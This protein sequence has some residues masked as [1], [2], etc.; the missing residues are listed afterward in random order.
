MASQEPLLARQ[1]DVDHAAHRS[2]ATGDEV[3]D[4]TSNLQLSIASASALVGR[5]DGVDLQRKAIEQSL[6]H[7]MSQ[8]RPLS[9]ALSLLHRTAKVYTLTERYLQVAALVDSLAAQIASKIAAIHSCAAD[10][11]HQVAEHIDCVFDKISKLQSVRQ[12]LQQSSS[13][14]NLASM[15]GAQTQ[16]A[17]KQ[18]RA[19]LEQYALLHA[20]HICMTLV[21]ISQLE[22]VC[23]C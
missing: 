13:C 3:H 11:H 2:V 8:T 16:C 5:V 12:R 14:V 21:V 17:F 20:P 1:C 7:S 22:C 19:V 9:L 6:S 23:W 15:V 4:A 10:E 18:L